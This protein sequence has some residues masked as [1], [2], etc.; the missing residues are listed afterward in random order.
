MGRVLSL[1]QLT[2]EASTATHKLGS[3]HLFCLITALQREWAIFHRMDYK[4]YSPYRKP[5]QRIYT[6]TTNLSLLYLHY[7]VK[8]L[9]VFPIILDLSRWWCSFSRRG[10][11]CLPCSLDA[12]LAAETGAGCVQWHHE[13]RAETQVWQRHLHAYSLH[14]HRAQ[15]IQHHKHEE[16]AGAAGLLG[17]RS[18]LVLSA[19]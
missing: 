19:P 10:A 14:P 15:T 6:R 11:Y 12:L 5:V 9:N 8:L 17:T 18:L 2:S 16:A 3:Y 4:L 7:W 1:L 13:G